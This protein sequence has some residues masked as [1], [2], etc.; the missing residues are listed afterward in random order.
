MSNKIV[1]YDISIASDHNPGKI[2]SPNTWKVRYALNVKKLDFNT[3]WLQYHEIEPTIIKLG[4]KPTTIK[5]D[6]TPWYTL[7]VIYDPATKQVISN[8]RNI[9]EYLDKQ[10]PTTQKLV[11]D[12]EFETEWEGAIFE[13]V[14]ATFPPSSFMVLHN[15]V[16]APAAQHIRKIRE[17]QFGATLE[18]LSTEEAIRQQWSRFEKGHTDLSEF[19][20]RAGTTF[21]SK[22]DAPMWADLIIGSRVISQKFL[23]GE[24]S[25]QWKSILEWDGGLWKKLNEAL[26]VFEGEGIE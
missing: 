1:F 6:G 17:A 22:G 26:Q 5:P 10:Y 14:S 13:N 16:S 19:Y 3:V 23:Y 2:F 25:K 7:P 8:S 18:D 15:R 20:K 9:A 21:L 24:D 4:G 12:P 11:L